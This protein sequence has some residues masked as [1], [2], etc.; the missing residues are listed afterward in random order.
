MKFS[1]SEQKWSR[2]KARVTFNGRK[3]NVN[4]SSL[5]VLPRELTGDPEREYSGD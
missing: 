5:V 4:G 3:K 2:S 1:P